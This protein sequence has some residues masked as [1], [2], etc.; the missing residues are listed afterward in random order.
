MEVQRIIFPL[1]I[2]FLKKM[3][4]FFCSDVKRPEGVGVGIGG[5]FGFR[6][7]PQTPLVPTKGV[8]LIFVLHHNTPHVIVSIDTLRLELSTSAE[9]FPRNALLLIV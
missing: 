8:V 5:E 2:F 1:K 7:N 9:E 3:H 4:T 6:K